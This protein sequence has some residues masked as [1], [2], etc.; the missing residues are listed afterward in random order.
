[1][2]IQIVEVTTKKLQREF[3]KLPWKIY[4][5]DPVW[6][7]P[8]LSEM[9]K[10]IRGENNT[11]TTSGPHVLILAKKDDE[12]VGRLC[13]GI[14]KKLNEFKN[15]N[16]GYLTLFECINDK[17][18]AQAIFDYAFKWLSERGMDSVIGPLAPPNGDDYRGLLI[19][20]FEDSPMVMNM[21]NPRYYNDLFTDNG[22]EKFWDFF[23]YHY[24]LTNG[25]PERFKRVSDYAQKR[26]KFRIEPIDLS[27]INKAARDIKKVLDIAMPDD[28]PD[29]YPPTFEDVQVIAKSLKPVADPDLVY[30]ARD[31]NDEAIGFSIALPDYNQALKHLNGR[32]LPFGFLKFLW[33]KRKINAARIFILFVVP[34]YQKKGVTAAI[35]LK[36]FEAAIRKGMTFGEGSTIAEKNPAMCRDAEG[37]GGKINKTF[38]I[39][40]REIS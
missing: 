2:T 36:S 13:I 40:K 26:Y 7:P 14:N 25:I 34:E 9:K 27:D 22:F 4:K 12:T 10:T 28:W 32:L 17:E 3:I 5:K 31:E 38:R 18:V 1:M 21:Y 16:Q 19:D 6:V 30:I 33:R 37:A 24:D 35:Y 39:Y 20:N 15:L 8:L 29:F 11:L 23:G